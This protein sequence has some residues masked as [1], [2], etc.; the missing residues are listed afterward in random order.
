MVLHG[1]FSG[2]EGNGFTTSSHRSSSHN[3]DS[4]YLIDQDPVIEE[5][6]TYAHVYTCIIL[7]FS[8]NTYMYMYQFPRL[9]IL[10]YNCCTCDD[11]MTYLHTEC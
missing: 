1:T 4:G 11:I 10:M 3:S 7:F 5:V 8:D 9:Y 2:Q 6:H